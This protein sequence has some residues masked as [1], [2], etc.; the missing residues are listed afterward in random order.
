MYA[1]YDF[2]YIF[3][4]TILKYQQTKK[5]KLEQNQRELEEMKVRMD[6]MTILLQRAMPGVQMSQ[7]DCSSPFMNILCI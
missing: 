6:W 2:D 1:V 5:L 3:D 7:T 4:W